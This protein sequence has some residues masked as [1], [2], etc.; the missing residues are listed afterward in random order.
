MYCQRLEV[1]KGATVSYSDSQSNIFC[2]IPHWGESAAVN[3]V[4]SQLYHQVRALKTRPGSN[5][6]VLV[7]QADNCVG[8]NKNKYVLA[9]LTC[10]VSKRWYRQVYFFFMMAGHT[11]THIDAVLFKNLNTT[12]QSDDFLTPRDLLEFIPAKHFH[13]PNIPQ[14]VFLEDI[15]DWKT[16]FEPHLNELHGHTFPHAF[17]IAWESDSDVYFSPTASVQ[18]HPHSEIKVLPF[19]YVVYWSNIL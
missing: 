18:C 8:E 15:Y 11:H 5:Q 12:R 10:L 2:S 6:E 13:Q 17:R 4:I 16:Y 7:V 1:N 19:V 3:L 14:L 9:F